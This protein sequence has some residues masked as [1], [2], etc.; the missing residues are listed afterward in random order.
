MQRCSDG[1]DRRLDAVDAGAYPAQ[2]RERRDDADR[3]VSAHPDASDVVEEDHAGC[4]G[5]V[6]RRDE[7]CAHD[8]VRAARLVDDGR[9]EWVELAPE[10]LATVRERAGAEI[11]AAAND[12]ARGLAAGVRIDDVDGADWHAAGRPM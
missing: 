2:V 7:Q 6:H 9:A 11:G 10:S 5:A 3:S 8:D 12:H 1:P 4:A